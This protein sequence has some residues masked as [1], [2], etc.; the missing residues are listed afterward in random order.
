MTAGP[1]ELVCGLAMGVL[2]MGRRGH[3][4]R[5]W[6]TAYAIGEGHLDVT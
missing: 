2:A 3:S 4:T 6:G 1:L 5:R